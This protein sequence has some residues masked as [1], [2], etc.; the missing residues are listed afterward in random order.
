MFLNKNLKQQILA[1]PDEYKVTSF[2]T[3]ELY[4]YKILNIEE[5]YFVKI[6]YI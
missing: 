2:C 5:F 6:I 3:S 4:S 1:K